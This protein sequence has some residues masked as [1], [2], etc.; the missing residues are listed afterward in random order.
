VT[1][2][3]VAR[4]AVP[5]A[6]DD[7]D[8]AWL[9]DAL[10]AKHPDAAVECVSVDA[11]DGDSSTRITLGV[12]YRAGSGPASVIVKAQG[13]LRHRLLLGMLG[14]L[15]G[16]ST[17]YSL[18]GELPVISP[19]I[20]ATGID[21]ATLRTVVVMEDITASG[22]KP[23][24]AVDPLGADEVADALSG[25]ASVH[26]RYWGASAAS[27]R[28][29]GR[30]PRR[31]I[32]ARFAFPVALGNVAG[33][34]KLSRLAPPWVTPVATDAALL[35]RLWVASQVRTSTR[36][37][38]TV[39]HGDAHVG[40]TYRTGDGKIG[41]YDWQLVQL[42]SWEHDV[43]YFMVSALDVGV[44]RRCERDLLAHYVEALRA[45][46][47]AA[48]PTDDE[49]WRAYRTTPAYGLPSWVSTL[50]VGTLQRTDNTMAKIERFATAFKDLETAKVVGRG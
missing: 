44:R 27:L 28:S 42:G 3:L 23:N 48:A 13:S 35:T 31:G 17:V 9:S 36:T 49:A 16:E 15:Y 24:Y 20:Y 6:I 8:A 37:P 30:L 22:G 4:C 47:V 45:A 18:G 50:G 5:R 40:N 7:Y 46:G 29:L 26:A 12:R 25:L 38:R 41:F 43:G 2:D 10:R 33:A 39:L 11:V 32:V 19:V 14:I 21:K 34:R 1:K